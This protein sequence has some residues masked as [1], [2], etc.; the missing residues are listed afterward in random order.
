[1]E[2]A[3][4]DIETFEVTRFCGGGFALRRDAFERAG[5]FDG[6]LFFGGEERDL[7]W[8]LIRLGYR[9]RWYRDLAVLH[10][11]TPVAKVNWSDRR[12]YF[13]VRN[14]LYINHK[15]GAGLTGLLRGSTSFTIRGVR[16]G[17]GLAALRGVGEAYAMCLRFSFGAKDK[18][19]YQLTP[20]MRRY[21]ADTDHKTNESW[22]TRIRRQLTPLP[23]V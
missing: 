3:D 7:S 17:L 18:D 15:Y 10:C 8:R 21:I 19:N 22:M 23:R 6:S 1:M 5:G 12:Y 4:S 14:T 11:S 2:Y 20:D 9:L 13:L 16:N